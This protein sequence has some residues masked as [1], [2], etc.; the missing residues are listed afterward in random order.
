MTGRLHLLASLAWRNIWRQPQRTALSFLSIGFACVVT[1]FVLA[2]QQGSY[3]TMRESVLRLF[4]G[5][6]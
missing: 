2:L 5:F 3:N 1:I 6:A 4:D